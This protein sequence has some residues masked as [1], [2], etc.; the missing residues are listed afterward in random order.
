M[1]G[2]RGIGMRIIG[3]STLAVFVVAALT[4][5]SPFTAAAGWGPATNIFDLTDPTNF[6][7]N[8][9][10]SRTATRATNAVLISMSIDT[11]R[12]S[13]EQQEFAFL[14]FKFPYVE[15][16]YVATKFSFVV[17]ASTIQLGG[18]SH[19][20]FYDSTNQLVTLPQ[21]PGLLY[22][23]LD[24]NSNFSVTNTLYKSVYPDA[25]VP[26]AVTNQIWLREIAFDPVNSTTDGD[27]CYFRIR[28]LN[29][30][31]SQAGTETFVVCAK[32]C[33]ADASTFFSKKGVSGL[34]L[35]RT[36][37]PLP[38]ANVRWLEPSCSTNLMVA[39]EVRPAVPDVV[40]P[41]LD[42]KMNPDGTLTLWT[43][44]NGSWKLQGASLLTPNATSDFHDLQMAPKV[45]AAVA[46]PRLS[47]TFLPEEGLRLFRIMQGP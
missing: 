33:G 6:P 44:A 45:D 3:G 42:I 43:Q 41:S 24:T 10:F 9:D 17:K 25:P 18:E 1:T 29:I 4:G 16:G 13:G 35:V 15:G 5:L 8:V 28:A 19:V 27:F 40:R 32:N 47:W 37:Q 31:N 46:P 23:T 14:E 22:S 26:N 39:L 38:Q 21:G 20:L 30:Y 11:F 7:P 12:D 34:D 36:I 2:T